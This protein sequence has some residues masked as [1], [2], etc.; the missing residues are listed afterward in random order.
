MSALRSGI[1]LLVFQWRRNASRCLGSG[2]ILQCISAMNIIPP[3]VIP[4]HSTP[5]LVRETS[6][7]FGR[8]RAGFAQSHSDAVV[9]WASKPSSLLS[10]RLSRPVYSWSISESSKKYSRV[11]LFLP[12]L[13]RARYAWVERTQYDALA[14]PPPDDDNYR[15]DNI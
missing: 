14:V 5:S 12:F 3:L 9:E 2:L 1:V 11:A 13:R 6:F 10:P 8:W 15:A 4:L 7:S